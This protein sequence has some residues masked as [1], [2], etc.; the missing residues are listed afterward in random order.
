MSGRWAR[1]LPSSSCTRR[2]LISTTTTSFPSSTCWPS[3]CGSS[4]TTSAGVGGRRTASG[5]RTSPWSRRWTTSTGVRSHLGLD[6]VAVLGHS[7]GGVLAMD[8]PPATRNGSPTLILLKHRPGLAVGP[9][10]LPAPPGPDPTAGTILD[11]MW[12]LAAT[13]EFRAGDLDVEAE[14]YRI[15]YRPTLSA[16]DLLDRLVPRLRT[17]FTPEGVLAARPPRTAYDRPGQVARIRPHPGSAQRR[18]A[19]PGPARRERLGSGRGGRADRRGD[20]RGS[21][22]VLPGCG[23]FAYLE[24]PD[25]VARQIHDLF[26]AAPTAPPGPAGTV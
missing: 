5:P 19:D 15:H 16:P 3:G 18:R 8:M 7:W 14:Y 12:S 9:S 25:A 1:G 10:H 24:Q 21:T 17:N 2:P 23:H 26:A 6:S 22:V 13:A 20:C 4:T 11:R